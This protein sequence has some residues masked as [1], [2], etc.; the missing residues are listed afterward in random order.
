MRPRA[1]LDA[2]YRVARY[3]IA[4]RG[5]RCIARIGVANRGIDQHLR[6]AGCRRH[7]CLLTPCNPG[8]RMLTP[9]Q[10]LGRMRQLR[11]ISRRRGW[12]ALPA[13]NSSADGEWI[14]PGLCLLDAPPLL[15]HRLA[16]RFGQRAWVLGRLGAA[17]QLVWTDRALSR[18]D[19]RRGPDPVLRRCDCGPSA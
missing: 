19:G 16:R 15:V 3:R 17:P 7:W 8:S 11:L 1:G 13:V 5:R 9:M 14:E 10:N 18:R 6:R 2:A 4:V 12:R